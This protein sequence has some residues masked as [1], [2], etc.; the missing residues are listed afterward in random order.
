MLLLVLGLAIFIGIHALPMQPAFRQDLA[1][2]Y[3]EAALKGVVSVVAA[4]GLALIVYG[5]HKAQLLPGKNPQVWSPPSWGRHATMA[6]MLP[7][8]PLLLAAYLSGRIKAAVRHPMIL[9]VKLWA[10]AHLLVRGDAAS[11]LLFGALLAWAVADRISLKRREAAGLVKPPAPGSVANDV[12][13]I[14]VGL[15]VYAGMAR[16]G[17]AWLIGVPLLPG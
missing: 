6:L 15:L 17:H 7:V 13:A 16:W 5:Y 9:A 12:I 8:F 10:L 11:M 4:A 2:R 3:G 14:V 1:S